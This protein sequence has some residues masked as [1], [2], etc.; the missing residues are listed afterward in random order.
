MKLHINDANILMDIVKLDLAVAFLA[1]GFE[2]YTTDFVFAEMELEQ[3]AALQSAVLVKLGANEADMNAIFEM[4][5]EH[6]GLSFEDCS[7]WYFAQKMD[8]ILV[9]GDGK[10]RTKASASGVEVRGMIYI[11]EQIKVQGLLPIITC[12]EKLR[13]LKELNDRL[14][15]AEIDTRIH[16]WENEINQ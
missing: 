2:L 13:L 16:A 14:P 9:T 1:L 8:G 4:T 11:I 5:E 10:L 12:V 6:A 7:T 3:Q 15:M